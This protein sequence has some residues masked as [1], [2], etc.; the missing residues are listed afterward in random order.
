MIK[1]YTLENKPTFKDGDEVDVD[2][3][4][5]GASD[6]GIMRGKVVGKVSDHIIDTWIVDFG[7]SLNKDKNFSTYPFKVV[8]VIHTAIV[9][10]VPPVL[11]KSEK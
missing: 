1:R 3:G 4:V 10:S 2:M 8:G 9:E 5:M 6:L 7:Q 11:G